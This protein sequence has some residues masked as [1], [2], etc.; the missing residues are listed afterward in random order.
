MCNPRALVFFF[1]HVKS[2]F[3]STRDLL[4]LNIRVISRLPRRS[5]TD[6]TVAVLFGGTLTLA[7]APAMEVTAGPL[8]G[9]H[10]HL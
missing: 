7:K 8:W 5:N 4:P 6:V 2:V 10:G 9:W 1:H 3:T